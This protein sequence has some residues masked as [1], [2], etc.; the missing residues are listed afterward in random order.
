[1][2]YGLA[3]CLQPTDRHD[4]GLLVV[5]KRRRPALACEQCR[6]RKVKCDRTSPCGPCRRSGSD[7]CTYRPDWRKAADTLDSNNRSR[8]LDREGGVA[9]WERQLLGPAPEPAAS[10]APP[11]FANHPGG[12]RPQAST[13][14]DVSSTD[15][16]MRP[17]L[18]G[19]PTSAAAGDSQWDCRPASLRG[20]FVKSRFHGPSHWINA[21]GAVRG[22]RV[23][24]SVLRTMI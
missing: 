20:S 19:G 23:S 8:G 2:E 17:A 6:R 16:L 24:V 13:P 14:S 1:M 12:Q 5:R 11:G 18:G 4:E 7:L 15:F 3:T 22:G 9:D 21:S 10:M